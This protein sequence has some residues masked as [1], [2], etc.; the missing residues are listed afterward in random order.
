MRIFGY[1]IKKAPRDRRIIISYNDTPDKWFIEL[2]VEGDNWG[3]NEASYFQ[4]RFYND[5]TTI[6][7]LTTSVKI[8]AE[9][10]KYLY[11]P[12]VDRDDD[13]TIKIL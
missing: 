13:I 1:E 5:S 4:R 9:I 3:F 10:L 7:N 8:T 11:R 2:R 6:N 12:L